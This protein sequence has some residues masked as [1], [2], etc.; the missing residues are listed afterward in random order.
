[1][2]LPPLAA[3]LVRR[4]APADRVEDAL[5]DL[6][7]VHRLRVEARGPWLASALTILESIELACASLVL[8]LRDSRAVPVSW[9]DFKLGLRMLVKYPGLTLVGGLAIAFGIFVGAGCY[10]VYSQILHPRLPI[11]EGERVV[12]VELFD[13]R[14]RSLEA[15]ILH[16]FA[17][18]RT[19]LS[20]IEELGAAQ[21]LVP[22][23]VTGE[24][25][26]EPVLAAAI[27]GSAF[28]M[29][30]VPP[31]MGRALVAADESAAAPDVVVIGHDVWQSRFGG[32]PDVVGRAAVLGG[33][34]HTVV[35]VMPPGFGFPRNQG[36]WVPLRVDP[37]LEPLRGPGVFV[38]GRLAPGATLGQAQSE[39]DA[40]VG[41][42]RVER[43]EAYEHLHARVLPYAEATAWGVTGDLTEQLMVWSVNVFAALFLVL[44]CGNVGLLMFARAA[45]R[46]E[47]I[48]VRTALGAGRRRIIG[49]LFSEALAL[50]VV[51]GLVGVTAAGYGLQRALHAFSGEGPQVFWHHAS[52]SPRTLGYAAALTV[53][54]AV[55]AGVVPGLKI[56]A[57]GVDSRLRSLTPGGG[58]LRFGG[59][60]TAVIVLQ[61]AATVTFPVVGWFVR[62][63]AVRIREYE[64]V[65]A[66]EEYLSARLRL[67]FGSSVGSTDSGEEALRATRFES[68]VR[69]LEARLEAEPSVAG[70]TMARAVPGTASGWRRIEMDAGGEAPRNE[71]D[72]KGAGR[73]VYGGLVA[74]DFFDV[75][76][77]EAVRGRTFNPDDA[78]PEARTVVVNQSFA[79]EVLGGRNPIGRRLRYL[80]SSDGW[81]G[82]ASADEPGPWYR[83]VGVVPAL[84]T[85]DT[86]SSGAPRAQLFHAV[87]PGSRWAATLIVHVNG[88]AAGFATRLRE[89]SREV[90]PDL[91]LQRL[92]PLD[93]AR[94]QDVRFYAFWVRMIAVVSGIA[95]L[96]SLAGIYSVMSFTVSRRTREIGVRVALGAG[97]ARVAA[98]IFRR[99]LLQIAAGLVV[100]LL[101]VMGLSMEI[102]ARASWARQLAML[103]GYA[104][105]MTAV[106]LSACVVPTRRALSVEPSEALRAET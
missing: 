105:V 40:W 25:N 24:G 67:N 103:L 29:M 69:E 78:D 33:V 17:A 1:M 68:T 55:I 9:I 54:A 65:F 102:D 98:A 73:Q 99:P 38:F 95:M 51:A 43:A 14:S 53:L 31:L 10:E 71:L 12:M 47:E 104:L 50:A 83:I 11:D 85:S 74:P 41:G 44:M 48:V 22:N 19:D 20:S 75:L 76:E 96:L 66:S 16:D 80:W 18:W 106:C 52:L 30:R 86:P 28:R 81:D 7:E 5:G 77:V 35:G 63:D 93:L 101:I 64:P 27:T 90:E 6:E 37:A 42:A 8:R 4:C 88:D 15:R 59:I 36:L 46:E 2:S 49:Q 91:A 21:P 56:T 70:V 26:G 3:F 92:Q 13:D 100:G 97:P 57:G 87:S 72:E 61:V 79:D 45:A 23:L 32:D 34:E 94:E 60:W 58:G 62:Q 39:M 89:L 84:G 82:A